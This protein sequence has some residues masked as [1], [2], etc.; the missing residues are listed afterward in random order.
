M[1]PRLPN[2]DSVADLTTAD[3]PVVRAMKA[4]AEARLEQ[5]VV[6]A[7]LHTRSFHGLLCCRSCPFC[8]ESMLGRIRQ[9]R[10]EWQFQLGFHTVPSMK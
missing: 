2:L 8:D 5:Y 9:Q 4:A 6:M 7:S 1:L 3:L 10:P